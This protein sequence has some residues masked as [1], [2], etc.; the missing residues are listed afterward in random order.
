MEVSRNSVL[1]KQ[2]R[3]NSHDTF[4]LPL[5]R[6][7]RRAGRGHGR[8]LPP[9]GARAGA[10]VCLPFIGHS[11]VEAT[12]FL[13]RALI[14]WV[15]PWPSSV[16]RPRRLLAWSSSA[17]ARRGQCAQGHIV[18]KNLCKNPD[19][20]PASLAS[21]RSAGSQCSRASSRSGCLRCAATRS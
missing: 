11:T 3:P 6:P 7:E 2:S 18:V 12:C 16:N 5:L 14:K 10:W 15:E 8:W 13:A 19:D 21:P 17:R 4:I 20:A 1:K 9:P